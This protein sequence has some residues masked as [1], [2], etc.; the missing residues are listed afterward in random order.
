M[1]RTPLP[2]AN[3]P[4]LP[5]VSAQALNRDTP[6]IY[7]HDLIGDSEQGHAALETVLVTLN[8]A[9]HRTVN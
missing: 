2:L 1:L 6:I 9:V 8:F 4:D 7:G 3:D 5:L